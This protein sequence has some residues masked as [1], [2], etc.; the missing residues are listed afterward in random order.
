MWPYSACASQASVSISSQISYLRWSVQMAAISGSV[1]RAIMKARKMPIFAEAARYCA[2]PAEP[3][4]S[5]LDFFRIGDS[6]S[7]SAMHVTDLP[8]NQA[9]GMQLAARESAHLLD[10]P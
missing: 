9:L 8:I 7:A 4:P 6:T 10:L 2:R 1:Y 3:A 5:P